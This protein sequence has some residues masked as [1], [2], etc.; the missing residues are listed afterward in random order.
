MLRAAV[1][2]LRGDRRRPRRA[3][4]IPDVGVIDPRRRLRRVPGHRPRRRLRRRP[5]RAR[6]RAGVRA[7]TRTPPS[8]WPRE[9][10]EI[11]SVA[12]PD[13]T[14]AELRRA[15]PAQRTACAPCSPRSRWRSTSTHGARRWSRSPASAASCWPST[16]AAASRPP[17]GAWPRSHGGR[18]GA[19]QHVG[20][21]VRQ[22]PRAQR[23]ALAR[24][25]ADAGGRSGAVRGWD[26]LARGGRRPDAGRRADAAGR[27]RRAAGRARHARVHRV[28]DGPGGHA[29]A[30]ADRRVRPRPRALDGRRR[31]APSRL[32]R[33]WS[34]AGRTTARDA[35]RHAARRHRPRRCVRTGAS[36]ACG[37]ADG[38]AALELA[39]AIRRVPPRAV[40]RRDDRA[41]LLWRT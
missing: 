33:R 10:P 6:R 13:A 16:T 4:R 36:P 28:R 5:R 18:S 1:L 38:V 35:R 8:C 23:H 37:G 14:H 20:G 29:R 21:R 15:V 39:E 27:G 41:W 7:P 31:S 2:G 22:R 26:R 34:R 25:A 24:P 30:G 40:A 3:R 17:S 11:V 19:L 12:T 9:A 32:P